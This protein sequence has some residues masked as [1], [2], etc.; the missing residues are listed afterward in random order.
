MKLTPGI[1]E[2]MVAPRKLIIHLLGFAI[3]IALLVW[4]II[5]AIGEDPQG[6]QRLLH[7]NPLLIAGMLGCT[8]VSTMLN[9]ANFWLTIR[10]LRRPGF[11]NLQWLNLAGNLLNYAPVRLGA[12]A[13]VAYHFRVDGLSLLQIGGWFAFIGYILILAVGACLLATFI[14][15]RIDWTWAALVL[16]QMVLGALAL[17]VFV[18]NR[19]LV[20]YGRGIDRIL[21]DWTVLWGAVLLR[22]LDL[23][24]FTGRMV[25]A[26]MIL[27][28]DL[29]LSSAAVLAVVALA[30]SLIPSGRLGFR[31]FCVAAA[32]GW[33]SMHVADVQ[34]NM[35]QL[36]LVESAG[37]ALV[38]LPLGGVCLLWY[39]HRWMTAGAR[40]AGDGRDEARASERN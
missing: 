15:D 22:L 29:P 16:G 28:I 38:Y 4:C 9:A 8:V 33:L 3:G 18:G 17:R 32:A 30:A 26:M 5:G 34:A 37:E 35:N 19:L 14:H 36:A 13:R 21:A 27:D 39:R 25:I 2:S 23:G 7:A 24:A 1:P 6:W 12:I 40:D 20:K 10:P 31:E 11:W